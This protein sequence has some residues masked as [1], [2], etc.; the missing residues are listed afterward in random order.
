LKKFTSFV[1]ALLVLSSL[2]SIFTFSVSADS[3]Y[4]R[5]IVSVVYDDSGSM[6]R[7][8]RFAYASYA[9]QTF[10]GMLN[11]EDQLFISYMCDSEKNPR[12]SPEQIDLSA[13]GIQRSVDSIRNHIG[14]GSTPYEAVE[15]AFN[16]LTSVNDSN[17]NT[18]YWLVV[19]T[20]GSF[21][22][23]NSM[24]NDQTKRFLNDKFK[25]Y[26]ETV[27]PNGT[28]PQVIFM[29]I[30]GVLSPD[31]DQKKGIFLSSAS[32]SDEIIDAMDEM[33]D[34]ISGRTRLQQNEIQ[35]IHE[36][37]IQVSSSIPLL[38]IAVL[39]QGSEAKI[40]KVLFNNEIDVPV[41]RKVSLGYPGYSD[42]VGGA[43][44]LGDSQKAI[45]SGNYTITFDRNVEL[46]DIVVLFEPALEMR[47]TITVNGR[48]ITD[49][50]ELSNVMENDSLSVSCKIYEMGT[51]TE[52]DPAL[53]P[54]G[55][56]FEITV[57]ENGT[58]VKKNS[59]KGMTLADY[60]LKNMETEI[61][62]AVMI[63]GFNPIVFSEKFTP[64]KY[65][66]K[67][68]YSI[69]SDYGSDIKSV[70]Y[71]DIGA[72]KDLTIQFTVYADGTPITDVNAV[73]ALNPAI[74]VS[75]A[76][77]A[78]NVTYS[79]D[80]KII[81]TPNAAG[82]VSSDS[83]SFDVSVTCTLS[84]GTSDTHTYTVLMA[85]YEVVPV[86]AGQAIKKTELYGNPVSVSFYILKD[87][88]KLDKASVENR[89]S[90]LLNEEHETLKTDVSVASDGT[91]TVRPY[92]EK[93]HALTFWSWWTN[94]SYY[95]GLEGQDIT[96]T[97]SHAFGTAD[98]TIDVVEE[99]AAYQILNVYLPLV[100]ELVL[101]G[102]LITWII[103]IITK[104]RY[105]E[106]ATLYVGNIK[107]DPDNGTHTIRNFSPVKLKKFNKIKKGNGRLKFK[108]TADVVSANG[109]K[110]R[111]DYGGRIICEMMFPWY[112][113]KVEPTDTDLSDLRTPDAI[114]EYIAR[115]KKLEIEEIATT[116]TVNGEFE[117]SITP[118]NPRM[119]KY[120]VI[121]DPGNGVAVVE[122][123]KVIRAGKLFIYVNE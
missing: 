84:D 52:I 38:N 102:F 109:I 79:N 111:A 9:M 66:P 100:L 67:I 56:K 28:N 88:V 29:G 80:G 76:G 65:V 2:I 47:M 118:A 98:S 106:S 15:L 81:F 41:S 59:G 6:D 77:N 37:T 54:P 3:L 44:L 97:L 117:R 60:I 17:P 23:C 101:L 103:L 70:K 35:K 50:R 46:D 30:G 24:T 122:D 71:D 53:L 45:G 92:S 33:A 58:E 16:K 96:V 7:D 48:E 51:D 107:Y 105:S 69:T 99:D 123:K 64:A 55:T 72:N 11:A 21:N 94:W 63:E 22:E 27:M 93:Q 25:N 8:D 26:A 20:D 68:V 85:S 119:A 116:V 43:F 121:P 74:Q 18:Q 32:S 73:K 91:I 112:K 5:K 40:T 114:A 4:I 36:N 49:Y 1:L 75:P 108:K 39:A 120:I 115:N 83:E 62:A 10:C 34:K 89:F 61:T 104:P 42:L 86:D 19:I 95:F 87:G 57:A 90:V 113:S 82:T 14:G 12:Y 110:V 31:E 78:G 13:S